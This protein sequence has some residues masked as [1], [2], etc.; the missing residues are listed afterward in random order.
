MSVTPA[1]GLRCRG[2]ISPFPQVRQPLLKLADRRRRQVR[3]QLRKVTLGI[4]PVPA[5]R[6]GDAAEDCRRRA[7]SLVADEQ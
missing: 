3:Q 4:D 1:V 2:R 5:T 7:T 6:A